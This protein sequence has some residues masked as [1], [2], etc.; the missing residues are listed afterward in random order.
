MTC[1]NIS[2]FLPL[3]PNGQGRCAHVFCGM[4]VTAPIGME[5]RRDRLF[6]VDGIGLGHGHRNRL[7]AIVAMPMRATC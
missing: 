4:N 3:A 7:A 5:K 6:R 2:K 1:E